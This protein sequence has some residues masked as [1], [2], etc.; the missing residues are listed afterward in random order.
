MTRRD[1]VGGPPGR[2]EAVSMGHYQRSLVLGWKL[3]CGASEEPQF[4]DGQTGETN[5]AHREQQV[6][7]LDRQT[8][9]QR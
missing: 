8:V 4:A 5:D 3:W 7:G 2:R 1:R 6:S 9:V